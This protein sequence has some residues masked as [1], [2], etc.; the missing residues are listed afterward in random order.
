MPIHRIQSLIQTLRGEHGCPWDR[1]QTPQSMTRY[2]IEEVYELA[3]AI[4]ADD[5]K[6]VCEEAGDVL[7]QLLF[8]VYLFK[9]RGVFGLDD[10]V[11]ANVAKMVRRHPHVF[12]QASAETPEQVRENWDKIKSAEKRGG[13]R[14]SVLDS[15]PRGLPAMLRAA[16][17]SA[18]AAKTGFDWNDIDGVMAKVVEE[19]AEFSREMERA[20]GTADNE[21]AATEFGDILFTMINVARFAH[22]DPESA[23][24]RSILKFE[25]RFAYMEAHALQAGKD[26]HRLPFQEMQAL[27]DEAKAVC[28]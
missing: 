14:R 5:A 15:I 19:W 6:G 7:F 25:Q 3:D 18:K 27:W 20:D 8:V 1:R 9:E 10:V 4:M 13:D 24:L 11:E 28:G 26:I 16:M 21:K 2:L 22:I 12:G 17:V 23:L